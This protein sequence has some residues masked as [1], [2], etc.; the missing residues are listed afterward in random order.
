MGKE[1]RRLIPVRCNRNL[2]YRTYDGACNNLYYSCWGRAGESF[3]RLLK[4]AYADGQF[5]EWFLRSV[6]LRA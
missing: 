1:A 4:P 6:F 3:S 2:R 5:W